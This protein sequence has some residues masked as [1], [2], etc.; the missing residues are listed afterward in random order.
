MSLRSRK[1]PTEGCTMTAM[2]LMRAVDQL[3][4]VHTGMTSH[5]IQEVFKTLTR[6]EMEARYER[7]QG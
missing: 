2:E 5:E 4:G 3:S 1:T 6:E 7:L